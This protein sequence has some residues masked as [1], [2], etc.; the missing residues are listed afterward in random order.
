MSNRQDWRTPPSVFNALQEQFG[1][2]S[3]DAA[4]SHD[5]HLCNNWIGE[6]AG[7]PRLHIWQP[8]TFVN[9]PFGNITPWV[10]QAVRMK[11]NHQYL[12]VMLTPANTSSSWFLTAI[13]HASL[14][15]PNR[16][17]CFWHPN[18]KV[19]S[20]DRDT[21]IFAF[22]G[23][24]RSN[25]VHDLAIPAHQ[26]EVKRLWQESKGQQSIFNQGGLC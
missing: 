4:A 24:Y 22:G 25:Q 2:F 12:T 20:P 1:E 6:K 11:D 8:G 19:G 7:D 5:N 21:V 15:L 14:F 17:I 13:N 23:K 10:L 26:Q 18:E 9:P 16:R 3:L